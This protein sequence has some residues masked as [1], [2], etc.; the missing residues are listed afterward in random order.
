MTESRSGVRSPRPVRQAWAVFRKEII[1]HIRDKRSLILALVYP[2]FG[3]V[4][5]SALILL[6]LGTPDQAVEPTPVAGIVNAAAAPD[7]VH[8]LQQN[9]ATLYRVT[10]N[11][12]AS[13]EDGLVPVVL[14]LSRN[15]PPTAPLQVELI[16]ASSGRN[17][18]MAASQIRALLA[19]YRVAAT[20]DTLVAQGL[21]RN[22]IP[23]IEVRT[24]SVGDQA[25]VT[26]FF[27]RLIP[28]LLLFTI[29]LGA[30]YVAVDATAGERERGSWEPLLTAPL[31]HSA[32]LV[33]KAGSVLAFTVFAVVLTLG[34]FYLL[35]WLAAS[36]W[37]LPISPPNGAALLFIFLIALPLMALAVIVQ[38]A[39]GTAA[40]SMKEAQLYLGLIPILPAIAGMTMAFAPASSH[41]W[42]SALPVVGHMTLFIRLISGE[43]I[44][45]SELI[46]SAAVTIALTLLCFALVKRLLRRE[47]VSSSG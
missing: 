38:M 28:P 35:P 33:G 18:A 16:L 9:G 23:S 27:Y 4:L 10:D 6:A 3:P 29:F 41:G 26:R 44:T 36:L 13:V 5:V 46:S 24:L 21:S 17:G 31:H 37:D 15:G 47:T 43:M 34:G 7:L 14:S 42:H 32:L 30:V 19:E 22:L 45:M 8:Y 2:L 25:D 11:A 1:D 20:A 39:I 12:T 40:R